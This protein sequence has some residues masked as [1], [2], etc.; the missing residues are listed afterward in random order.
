MN[1]NTSTKRKSVFFVLSVDTEE[2]WDWSGP[3][4]QHAFSVENTANIPKFQEFCDSL[5]I[6]PTYFVDYAIA[7][8]PVS[9][10]RLK[11]AL[12]KGNCEIGGHLHP[13][14]TPPVEEDVND[15]DN[16]H[17]IN[18]PMDL[19]ERKLES[20]SLKLEKEFG[21]K[22][23]SFR[24]G[25]WGVTGTMLKLLAKKGYTIDSSIHPYYADTSFSYHEA[26]DLPY[27]PDYEKCTI[28]GTQ[29]EIYEMPVTSG[30]NHPNFPWWNRLH[31]MLST[32]PLNHLRIVGILWK[33]GLV[34]KIHLSPELADTDDMIALVKAAL[35][36]GHRV[37]HMYCHSPSLLPSKSAPYVKNDA[38]E[39]AFYGSIAA[40]YRYLQEH[41]D[42]QSCTL[43]VAT[44]RIMKEEERCG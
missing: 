36:G 3:F 16:S 41:T 17:A 7:N 5:G 9:V 6:K 34:R 4:P 13:W 39:E 35:K 12:D 19:V 14:C 10:Q 8:D 28:P 42:V 40:V 25:R 1:S 24:S 2:E 18:L 44:K 23:A 43:E 31:L 15:A 22:P 38:D 30:Y 29:R 20:L 27:W 21:K 33:L 32:P 37:I 11:T 26:P